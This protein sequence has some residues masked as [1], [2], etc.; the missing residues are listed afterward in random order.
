MEYNTK[1]NSSDKV[2]LLSALT[3]QNY[4]VHRS[5]FL[6]PEK[7]GLAE[8]KTKAK[9]RGENKMFENSNVNGNSK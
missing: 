3:A 6:L 8:V 4:L 1:S 2:K 7:S 9:T 5:S